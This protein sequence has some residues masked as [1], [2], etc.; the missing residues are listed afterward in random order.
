MSAVNQRAAE[1]I[2]QHS[3][4]PTVLPFSSTLAFAFRYI[5]GIS[6]AIEA[7]RLV[8][9]KDERFR[10]V[11]YAYEE[12][13]ESDRPKLKLEALCETAGIPTS[14]FL[15]STIA[16]IHSRN[17]DIGK[18]IAS[19]A[20]PKVVEATIENAQTRNGFMDRK[21]MHDHVG[22]LP[23]PKGMN[24]NIDNSKKT[25]VAGGESNLRPVENL[26]RTALPSFEDDIT[27]GTRALRGDAGVGSVQKKLP[28]PKPEQAVIVPDYGEDP[29]NGPVGP[30][31]LDAE[32]VD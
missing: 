32:P 21:M 23:L 13:P 6:A 9:E 22:F 30:E 16:A 31:I 11:V 18:L 1:K 19:A 5:G 3:D 27:Q 14:E 28:A 4:L 29:R 24:I 15:G 2:G 12:T 25:L 17:V 26:S 20:H 7:A 10:M 8:G